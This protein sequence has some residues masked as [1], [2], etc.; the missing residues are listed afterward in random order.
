MTETKPDPKPRSAFMP[1]MLIVVGLVIAVGVVVRYVP[2]FKCE[3][4]VGLGT[5]SRGEERIVFVR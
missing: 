1:I 5:I 2:F 3:A 4:C